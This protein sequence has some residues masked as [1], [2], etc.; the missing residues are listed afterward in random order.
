MQGSREAQLAKGQA[1]AQANGK[2]PSGGALLLVR[3]WPEAKE[4]EPEE[5]FWDSGAP[6]AGLTLDL[7][8]ASE[9][10]RTATLGRKIVAKVPSVEAA[11]ATAR[12]LQWAIQGFAEGEGLQETAAAALVHGGTELPDPLAGSEWVEF[13]QKANPGQILLTEEACQAV[14]QI[15]GYSL[16]AAAEGSPRE[17]A[18]QRPP[19]KA[20]RDEDEK[21]LNRLIELSGNRV[22]AE[23]ET[24]QAPLI[25]TPRVDAED[26]EVPVETPRSSRKGLMIAAAIVVVLGLSALAAMYLRKP[27]A[28]PAA[29]VPAV[30]T[31]AP[32]VAP[33]QPAATSQTSG[34]TPAATP[35][36]AAPVNE[37]K[38]SPKDLRALKREQK[39]E[40]QQASQGTPAPQPAPAEVSDTRPVQKTAGGRCEVGDQIPQVLDIAKKDLDA[41]RYHQAAQRFSMVLNCDQ[42]N[43]TAREGLQKAR[44]SEQENSDSPE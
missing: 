3:L 20:D 26:L 11:V 10:V 23:E 7:I 9:G 18:W 21:T 43:A 16:A 34:T 25:I 30:E 28:T 41:G 12:R 38:L 32:P 27:S 15:A 22:E 14:E 6:A 5:H 17:L 35:A 2:S 4:G 1:T 44:V 39:K 37:Q 36:A 24:P 29:S 13:L 40:A 31:Q 33:A 42:G 19:G 8:A